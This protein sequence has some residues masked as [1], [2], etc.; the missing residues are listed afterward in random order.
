MCVCVCVVERGL[1]LYHHQFIITLTR[2]TLYGIASTN[3]YS[4][5]VLAASKT[6]LRTTTK[7]A[8]LS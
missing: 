5:G 1:S 4:G 7:L 3:I 2:S 8:H 6:S